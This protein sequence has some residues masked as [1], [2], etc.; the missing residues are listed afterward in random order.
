MEEGTLQN[1]VDTLTNDLRAIGLHCDFVRVVGS[2]P[3]DPD[4]EEGEEG[5]VGMEEGFL[6]EAEMVDRIKS[7]QGEF[8]LAVRARTKKK[9][10]TRK[11]LDP[12][13]YAADQQFKD[14]GPTPT[15]MIA[16]TIKQ[17]VADGVAIEDIDLSLFTMGLH[18]DEEAEDYDE[19]ETHDDEDGSE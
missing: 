3:P 15:E 10:W 13:G 9:A 6:T 8:C 7:E 5:V 17:Q 19:E 4:D 18:M 16:E 1:L 2:S 11:V 14:A 12:E